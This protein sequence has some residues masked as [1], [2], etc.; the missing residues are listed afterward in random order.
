VFFLYPHSVIQDELVNELVQNEYE[1]Y[2]LSDHRRAARALA[3]FSDSICFINIDDGMPE[4]QWEQYVRGITEN[5]ATK[6]VRIG[7][8][9]YNNDRDLMQ[10]YLMDLGVQ[11]GYV[12]LK[13]GIE[14]STRI[15]LEVLKANE[16]KGRRQ[17]VRANCED[18]RMAVFNIRQGG[19]Q[20]HGQIRDLSS[21]GMACTFGADPKFVKG[22]VL[23][24]VQLRLR[25][26]VVNTGGVVLG[27]R[28]GEPPVY[29]VL[30]SESREVDTIRKIRRYVHTTLQRQMEKE[31]SLL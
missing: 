30:F 14:Q 2:F 13:L 11:C 7:I 18:D 24:D 19:T 26:Q 6:S 16:A 31:I 10:K 29:V 4:P 5:P 28:A 1:V 25:G 20:L 23:Q 8:L 12:Q 3:H 27:S 22:T 17:F 15:V 9:S 21:R